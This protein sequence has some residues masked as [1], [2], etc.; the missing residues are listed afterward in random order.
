[1]EAEYNS[2]RFNSH[3]NIKI[4]EIWEKKRKK[5]N[6]NTRCN[7]V[8]L[9]NAYVSGTLNLQQ[10]RLRRNTKNSFT[11]VE[12]GPLH[13]NG[14]SSLS[15]IRMTTHSKCEWQHTQNVSDNTLKKMSTTTQKELST[16]AQENII[17]RSWRI[18]LGEQR[19]AR[20]SLNKNLTNWVFQSLELSLSLCIWLVSSLK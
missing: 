5:S 6:N 18:K 2:I 13:K 10:L 7:G 4:K 9:K 3:K 16:T 17:R 12:L 1:M 20:L 11:L 8:R 14:L 19:E 15:V